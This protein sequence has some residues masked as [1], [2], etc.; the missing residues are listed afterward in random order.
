[1]RRYVRSAGPPEFRRREYE[2]ML[3][4]YADEIRGMLGKGYIGTRICNELMGMGYQG[5]LS[6]VHRY[7]AGIRVEEE[8]RDKATTRVEP[9]AGRQMQYDWKEWV[10]SV[11]GTPIKVYIHEVVLSYSRKKYYTY[12]VSISAQ[13][14]IRAIAKGIEFF[15]GVPEELVID[16]PKQM[17]I[18]HRADGVI[19]YNDEFLRF[20]GLYGL[21][22]NPCQNYRA[23]TKGKA[24]RPFYYLQEHLL[25][26]LEVEG[27]SEFDGLLKDFRDRYNAR[28]HSALKES[29]DERFSRELEHLRAVPQ[30]EPTVLYERQIRKVTND[31][32]ISWEGNFYPVPMR[33]CMREVLVESIFGRAIKIYDSKG[34]GAAE[35][36]ITL[37]KGVRPEHPEHKVLNEGYSDSKRRLRS[38]LVEK[39]TSCFGST[40]EEYLAGLKKAAGANLYWHLSEIVNDNRKITHRDNRKFTHPGLECS[41]L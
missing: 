17:V 14:V 20:C 32:Y 15:Q 38:A 22:P 10:L 28:P 5:S 23:R 6:S 19:R 29:P 9:A 25:K 1:M 33:L 24:E 36:Q 35:H 37:N 40:G 3:D 27:F 26:G 12:S 30:V 7:I 2:R 39:F 11:G 4:G 13:D 41:R 34:E 31:G 16:N 8:I 21:E 18:T